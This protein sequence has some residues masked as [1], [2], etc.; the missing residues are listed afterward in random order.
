ME[1]L[2]FFWNLDDG[3]RIIDWYGLELFENTEFCYEIVTW[4]NRF[5]TP[6]LADSMHLICCFIFRRFSESDDDTAN[7]TSFFTTPR[8][9]VGGSS[10]GTISPRASIQHDAIQCSSKVGVVITSYRQSH[11]RWLHWK[12]FFFCTKNTFPFDYIQHLGLQCFFK[13]HYNWKRDWNSEWIAF[14]QFKDLIKWA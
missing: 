3:W 8:G 12:W 13:M 11:R 6:F 2:I 7:S 14:N 9:S 1:I 10:F 4:I 5:Y